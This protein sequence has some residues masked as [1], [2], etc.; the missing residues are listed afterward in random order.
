MTGIVEV[1]DLGVTFGRRNRLGVENVSFSIAAGERVG[2]IGESGSGKSVTALAIMG[3]LSETAAATGS[4]RLKGTDVLS[5]TD[6]EL[7]KLRGNVVSMVFQEPMTALDP[8]MRVGRQ[9]AEVLRLHDDTEPGEARCRVLDM[10]ANVGLAN[11]ERVCDAFPFQLSGGQRQRCIL[12]M[13]L[14]NHPDL[15][16]CDEPTTALDVTVQARVLD[17]LDQQLDAENAACLFISHDLAVV[18]RMCE[19]VMV[20]L[21]G[22]IVEEGPTA[23]IFHSPRHPYTKGLV[24]TARIADVPPGQRLQTVED[25]WSAS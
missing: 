5:A 8:T 10:L 7:S 14:I 15:I 1:Q 2:L 22:K 16:I 4:I 3:L 9:I 19:R 17:V 11:P 20:M 25:F 18:S 13:A 12:A 6:K 24:A 21:H 23:E